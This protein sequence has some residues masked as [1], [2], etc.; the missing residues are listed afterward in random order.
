MPRLSKSNRA[1]ARVTHLMERLLA[2]ANHELEDERALGQIS[3]RWLERQTH[4]PKLVVQTTLRDLAELIAPASRDAKEYIRH[5][6]HLLRDFLCILEDNRTRTQGSEV[7]HFTLRLWHSSTAKNLMELKRQWEQRKSRTLN[8]EPASEPEQFQNAASPITPPASTPGTQLRHNLPAR[9][10]SRFI[11]RNT[12]IVQLLELLHPNH[13]TARIGITG[14]GGVGKTSLVLQVAYSCLS[15]EPGIAQS[16]PLSDG[17]VDIPQFDTIIFV[18]AKSQHL[19]NQGIL[20]HLRQERTLHQICRSIL[21]TLDDSSWLEKDLADQINRIY[22]SF[23]RQQVLLIVDNLETVEEAQSVL[24]FLYDLPA[25]VKVIVT[26][27][28]R[29]IL[30]VSIHLESLPEAEG[31][32]FIQDQAQIKAVNLSLAEAQRLHQATGGIPA[33]IVYAMGQL[34]QGYLLPDALPRLTLAEGDFCRFYFNRSVESLRGQ[35]AHQLL[36]GLA[37]FAKP[38]NREAVIQIALLDA[39]ATESFA[40][41]HQLSLITLQAEQYTILPLTREFALTELQANPEF[42]QSARVRW[43]EWYLKFC[44]QHG[45]PNWKAWHEY[46]TLN[47]EWENIQAA[48]E[49][50]IEQERYEEFGQFWNYVKG[51]TH[52]CGY[53]N[54]RLNWMHWWIQAAQQR[55]DRA[56]QAQGQRD[57]AW[58]L[59]LKGKSDG[60]AKAE[61]LLQQAWELHDPVD[62]Q[63]QLELTLEQAIL[64]I[65]QNQLEVVHHWLDQS[66]NLLPK[67]PLE[68]DA[69]LCHSIRLDYYEAQVWYRQGKHEQARP[70]FQ[71]VLQAAQTVCWQQIEIYTLNW[72]AEIALKQGDLDQAEAWLSQSL[73][74]VQRQQDKRSIAFHQRSWAHLEQL[75]GNEFAWR[76][77]SNAALASFADLGMDVEVQEIQRWLD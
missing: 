44:Q 72:L 41:L 3:V 21:Q 56:T 9:N 35:P 55:A 77:W 46:T 74:I 70:L 64:C 32:H 69:Q 29:V 43:V 7:W 2:Y 20:P 27:C 50:C 30:D 53:M 48:I 71:Q 23:V 60:L 54:E 1:K 16:Q 51:Y 15:P 65:Y 37:L 4:E 25:T 47:T 11:G 26:S 14:I 13:P 58:T 45:N 17:L 19:T 8:D 12:Q 39:E 68:A 42:E 62:L 73:P 33:A 52:L 6:L 24:A 31:I 49:W 75:R 34:A 5:D 57:Y 10:Y 59:I 18:S 61:H 67:V 36:M 28:E 63:F 40:R 66:R 76:H 22:T 38:T